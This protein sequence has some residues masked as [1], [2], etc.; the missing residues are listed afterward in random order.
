MI[1]DRSVVVEGERRRGREQIIAV[2]VNCSNPNYVEVSHA[3][4]VIVVTFISVCVCVRVCA[5]ACV[6]A[7]VCVCVCVCASAVSVKECF[8]CQ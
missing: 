7:C 4:H 1:L 8:V 6:R 3:Q 2:G 5:C